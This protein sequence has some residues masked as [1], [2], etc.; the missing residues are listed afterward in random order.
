MGAQPARAVLVAGFGALSTGGYALVRRR[1]VPT[2]PGPTDIA[3]LGVATFKLSRLLTKARITEFA[4]EPFVE[5]VEPGADGEVN[6]LPVRGRGLR[7][8]IGELLTCPFC[9]SVWIATAFVLLFSWSP[10]RAR[11][12][13][14]TLAVVAVADAG[15]HAN[16][17]L[18]RPEQL[19]G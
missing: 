17:L 9:I 11:L 7:S 10:R 4:R 3:L 18:R 19:S 5:R 15:Q 14:S 8:A 12:V 13:S 1:R 16:E 2:P 6:A